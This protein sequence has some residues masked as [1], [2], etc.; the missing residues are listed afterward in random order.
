MNSNKLCGSCKYYEQG[1]A[2]SFC[3]HKLANKDEKDYRYYN[4]CCQ[5]KDKYEKG[6]AQSR[7]DW[8]NSKEGKKAIN[9][10]KKIRVIYPKGN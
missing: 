7:I 9:E 8:M 10:L 6:I 1:K 3:G 5:R 4:C 2:H